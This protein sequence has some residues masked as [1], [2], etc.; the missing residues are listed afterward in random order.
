MI[1][2]IKAIETRKS[3]RSY[4]NEP[5]SAQALDTLVKAAQSAPKAGVFHI[6]V[7]T[8]AALLKELNDKALEAM[9][10]SGNEF[11]MGRAALEGYQPLYGA[12]A[13]LL[14]SAPPD[15][16][17]GPVTCACA[18]TAATLAATGQELGS[19]YVVTPTLVLGADKELSA[20]I[21]IPEGY[22]VF[23]GVLAGKM[24]PEKY[25]TT[26]QALNNVNYCA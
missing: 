22:K 5:L 25:P 13:I 1:D 21:G 26:P 20:Q 8:N 14:L 7:L 9:K 19:C 23:C 12:P 11:L 15:E 6:T 17:Y 4:I 3:A 18:A 16:H 24:G 10:N 2:V